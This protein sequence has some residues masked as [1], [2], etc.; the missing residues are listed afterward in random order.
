MIRHPE[1]QRECA[2]PAWAGV[3]HVFSTQEVDMKERP[4][5]FS[6]PMVRALLAGTKTQTR[7]P[8]KPQSASVAPGLYADRYNH[9]E[10]WAYWLPDGRMDSP[11]TFAC[12]YG[13]P[14]DRLW[15][16]ETWQAWQRVSHEYDE[17][18]PITRD[19][20][21]GTQWAE[22]FEQNGDPDAIEYR[23]T[24]ESLGPWEPSIYMPRWASRLTLEVTDVRVER[25]QGISEE[26]ARA[27]GVEASQEPFTYGWRNYGQTEFVAEHIAYFVTAREAFAS[28]WESINGPGSWAANPWVWVIEFKRLGG[29]T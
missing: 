3:A 15:V 12:P 23:A 26:D 13:A 21:G 6:A 11:K 1:K 28:L 4:I 10:R 22:W 8:V 7:R 2:T 9:S 20:R 25:L 17:W 24:G 14:G 5:I 18:E 19:A 16:R 27:E 29:D